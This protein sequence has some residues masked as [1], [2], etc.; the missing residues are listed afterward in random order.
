MKQAKLT[1]AKF[2]EFEP[3]LIFEAGLTYGWFYFKLRSK[4]QELSQDSI[5]TV[6]GSNL[7]NSDS[8]PFKA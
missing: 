5:E 4:F 7:L 1:E 3:R 8:E 2:K 6:F